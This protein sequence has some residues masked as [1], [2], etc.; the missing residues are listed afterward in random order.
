M[1]RAN[2]CIADH[3]SEVLHF[4]DKVRPRRRKKWWG[5]ASWMVFC[6]LVTLGHWIGWSQLREGRQPNM[7]RWHLNLQ[8]NRTL[9]PSSRIQDTIREMCACLMR[10][11]T[12]CFALRHSEQ[13]RRKWRSL[14]EVVVMKITMAKKSVIQRALNVI[15]KNSWSFGLTR[16]AREQGGHSGDF[17]NAAKMVGKISKSVMQ[18]I[19]I[20]FWD[21]F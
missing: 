8:W 12:S 10:L 15:C 6:A 18:L 14:L 7:L 21:W 13:W 9:P 11:N 16:E 3:A 1:I 2:P 20:G 19:S 5:K 4:W 17:G